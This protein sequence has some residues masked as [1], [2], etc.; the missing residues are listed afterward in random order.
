VLTQADVEGMQR[1]IAAGKTAA[2]IK[3]K[4]QGKAIIRGGKGI[5]SRV[6][7]TVQGLLTFGISR[8]VVTSNV[9]HGVKL[10]KRSKR[11][12]FLSAQEVGFIASAMTTMLAA[13]SLNKTIAD[14]LRSLMLT[15]A[16]KSEIRTLRWEWLDVANGCLRLPDSK[17]GAKVVPIG[18]AALQL[19]TSRPRLSSN[20][21]VFPSTRNDGPVTALQKAWKKVRTKATAIAREQAIRDG[22]SADQAPDLTKIRIH[23]LRHSYASVAAKDGTSLLMIAKVLGQA[24][25]RTTEIYAHLHD[26]PLKK[27]ADRTAE[28]IAAAFDIG[29]GQGRPSAEVVEIGKAERK[30]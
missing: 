14:A 12:R 28:R 27:V 29:A 21:H 20:A 4:K 16:R 24:D 2:V 6:V 19:L 18:A 7:S 3:T 26:D 10:Y 23:D 1:D 9:A 25:T 30:A 17:T 22:L 11:E 13:G 5:A 8:K 15:G